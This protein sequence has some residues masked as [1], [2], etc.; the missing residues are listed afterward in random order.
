MSVQLRKWWQVLSIILFLIVLVASVR[1]GIMRAVDHGVGIDAEKKAS[2]WS[3]YLISNIPDLPGLIASGQPTKDQAK[4]IKTAEKLGDVFR[5]KLFD[6]SGDLVLVSDDIETQERTLEFGY[7][8]E[9]AEMVLKTGESHIELNDGTQ[10]ENRPDLYVEAYVPVIQTSGEVIG[11]AELYLDQ[12]GVSN[13][14]QNLFDLV[15]IFIAAVVSFAFAVPYIA[16]FFKTREER[17]SRNKADYLAKYDQVAKVFNRRG[18]MDALNERC[19]KDTTY[20]KNSCT[21]FLDIDHF[22]MVNDTYGHALGDAFLNHVGS[23]ITQSISADDLVGRIGGDEFMIV[24]KGANASATSYLVEKIQALISAPVHRGG[25][26]LT[27]HCSFGIYESKSEHTSLQECMQK[28]DIALYQAKVD[29]RNGYRVFNKEMETHALRRRHV[30][31]AILTGLDEQRFEIYFQP[32]LHQKTKQCAGFEALLRLKD[33][34]GMEIS[35]TEFIPIAESMGEIATIGAWVLKNSLKLISTGPEH[36]FVSVNLSARQFDDKKLVPLV[37]ELLEETGVAPA[38]LELEVTE[39]LLMENTD[40]VAEQMAELRELGVSMAMD[41]FGTGYSSLGYLWKF[42]F[43]KL[44]IDRSF[45]A[46][47]DHTSEK[48]REILETIIV[49][50]HRLDMTVTAEGIENEQQ[51]AVLEGLDCDHFQGFLYG[52]PMPFEQIAPFLLNN[53]HPIK[54]NPTPPELLVAG[55]RN[56]DIG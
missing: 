37:K 55:N 16:Y 6:A 10:K 27:G 34:N 20:L 21:I 33:S 40:S 36:F 1:T 17:L 39:S 4:Y 23:A 56:R 48:A 18:L 46:G 29:G 35:P 7:H 24:V 3:S 5:F 12:T 26:T 14:F 49:L 44:K 52:K 32:L 41:D 9:T 2:S 42:G 54:T 47:L 11:V 22:K 13:L 30:E 43:D 19:A 31:A 28:A 45:V 51:A 53:I 38:R 8:N 50:G 15:A 25:N